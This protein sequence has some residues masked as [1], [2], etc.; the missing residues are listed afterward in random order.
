MVNLI[1]KNKQWYVGQGQHEY[2]A[3]PSAIK[4]MLTTLS[5]MRATRIA[6]N[7]KDQWKTYEVDDTS[8]THILVNEGKKLTGDLY[9]GKFSYQQPKN[10]NPYNYQQQVKMTSY[11]RKGGDK[12]VYAVDGMI[13][14][15]FNREASDFRNRALI[16]SDIS[17]WDHLVVKNP[18]GSFEFSKIND[19]WMIDGESADSAT[20]TAYLT[21]LAWLNSSAFIDG[22]ML[23]S[24][25]PSHS[26][27]IDGEN[28]GAP[29][30]INAFP[31]DTT[32]HYAITSSLNEG[33]Y[34]SGNEN[35]LF[36]KIFKQK[37][38]FLSA[39]ESTSG[40]E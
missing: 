6:S 4:S 7:S 26:L 22:S 2:N 32:I 31:A 36:D 21:S 34:F 38:Y 11:V 3:D 8:A 40:I 35:G 30:K 39:K 25:T 10:R 23:T 17:K 9:L 13:A 29:I 24:Q 15:T 19:R 27:T 18:A 28:M 20:V 16:R 5:S 14:M 12:K 33:S 1:K 37:D